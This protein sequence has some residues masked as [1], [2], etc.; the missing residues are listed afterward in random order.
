MLVLSG[1]VLE[2]GRHFF[3]ISCISCIFR[4]LKVAI[5]EGIK[6]F[7]YSCF[8]YC[9]VLSW[10]IKT[11]R[12]HHSDPVNHPFKSKIGILN[13]FVMQM[14]SL[15]DFFNVLDIFV[16]SLDTL[17]LKGNTIHFKKNPAYGRQSISRPMRIV[18]LIPQ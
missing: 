5:T 13:S 6:S 9:F 14:A 3:W 15:W 17:N 18:A 16:T 2:I 1:L 8:Y 12:D 7:S 11:S 10:I 4:V